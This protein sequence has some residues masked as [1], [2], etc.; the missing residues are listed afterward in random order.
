MPSG[1]ARVDASFA[2]TFVDA[3]P[4][5]AVSPVSCLIRCRIPAAIRAGDPSLR[6]AE[7]TSTYPSS[8]LTRETSG[9][10]RSTMSKTR[11]DQRLY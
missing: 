7:E 3:T 4:T 11:P 2:T 8:M 5:D 10:T 1:L 6:S 9:V